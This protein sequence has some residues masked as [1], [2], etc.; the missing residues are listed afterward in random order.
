MTRPLHELAEVVG[1]GHVLTDADQRAPYEVDWSGRF[2]GRTDT[3]V[4]PADGAEVAGVLDVCRRHG[5]A[6]VPQGGNTG[7]VGGGVPL[8]GELV[9]SLRRLDEVG[10]DGDDVVARAGAPR[11]RV[12][13]AAR[14]VGQRYA[15]DL[16][17]RDSATVG[18]SVSTDAG[19]LH[20]VRHGSTRAQLVGVDAVLGSGARVAG[21]EGVELCG[22]EG[23][24]GVVT[25]ARLRL[26]PAH[27]E[28]V[29][30]LVGFGGVDEAVAAVEQWRA[31]LP[32][33]E[34]AELL[35]DTGLALVCEAFGLT[36]PLTRPWPAVVLVEAAADVDPTA[37]LAEAVDAAGP[38][39]VAVAAEP[40]RRAALWRYREDL[41]P[42]ISTVGVPHKLD[43]RVP[44]ARLAD[45]VAEVP[46]RVEATAPDARTWI[47]GH[48]GVGN[49]HVNVTG[50]D[51]DD[52][53]V[54]D[55]VL[56]HVLEVGGDLRAEHGVGTAKR[57]WVAADPAAEARK[58]ALDPEGILNPNVQIGSP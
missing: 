12:Q 20:V 45:F 27:D 21:S 43:V 25:A 51:P 2:R 10:V 56:T 44:A 29:V 18:G 4:R 8:D 38:G 28:R 33:L 7:L 32:S 24:L 23:T 9:L 22:T 13:A 5:W 55:V 31:E 53:R 11:G 17:A 58:R 41:T 48:L 37:A 3:V 6:V 50:V 47:F 26:V 16:A 57:R 19:G 34:A 39:E 30:A 1:P 14:G 42:A 36:P 54:D 35:L 46:W 15:V 52:E 49:L 40:A